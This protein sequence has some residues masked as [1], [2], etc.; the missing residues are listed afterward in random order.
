MMGTLR[1]GMLLLWGAVLWATGCAPEQSP[2]HA[3]PDSPA[4]A[5]TLPPDPSAASPQWRV[6]VDEQG[7]EARAVRL[8]PDGERSIV[9][10]GP[11]GRLSV[12]PHGRLLEA[13]LSCGSP[14]SASAFVSTETGQ[15]SDLFSD[16]LAV[17]PTRERVAV[18]TPRGVAVHSA[19]DS[20]RPLLTSSL[21]L[22]A[23][24]AP[25]SA[26]A[27]VSFLGD[28]SVRVVYLRGAEFV[29]TD[30]TIAV[31]RGHP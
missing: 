2:E 26:F 28:G 23:T 1:T 21:P 6:L 24:A 12:L 22:S 25:I 17:D 5:R 7:D 8:S 9:I 11:R 30:T 13:R 15:T 14:C 18:P 27:D 3:L 16:V 19:W 29:E 20:D 4:A 31:P 10:E